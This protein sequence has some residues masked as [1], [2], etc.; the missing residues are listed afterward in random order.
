MIFYGNLISIFSNHSKICLKKSFTFVNLCFD[1]EHNYWEDQIEMNPESGSET[2]SGTLSFTG[3][4]A[5]KVE[6]ESKQKTRNL[7]LQNVLST[8]CKKNYLKLF[9]SAM[10]C[11]A[12]A[13]SSLF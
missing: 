4:G 12:F 7:N 3:T 2:G 11:F 6:A 10:H 13:N 9:F 1:I 8:V 5:Y